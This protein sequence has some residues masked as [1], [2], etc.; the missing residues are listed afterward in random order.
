MS[1]VISSRL[2]TWSCPLRTLVAETNNCRSLQARTALKSTKRSIKSFSGLILSGLKSYGDRYRVSAC[3]QRPTGVP[4]IGQNENRR[5]T[6]RRCTSGRFPP[7]LAARQNSVSRLRA[8]S[9]PPRASPS[10][11]MIAL[12]AP[13]DAPDMPSTVRRPSSSRWSITPQVKAPNAP[14]PCSA[15]LMRSPAF[16]E[17][18]LAPPKARVR[19][20]IISGKSLR[21]PAAVDRVG[22]A[23]YR[24]GR[25]AAEEHGKRADIF[26]LGELVHR[27]FLGHQLDGLLFRARAC[28]LGARVD[29]LLHERRQHPAGANR[30]TGYAIVCG[31]H[32]NNLGQSDK[33]MFGGDISN[34]L[35]TGH[36]TVGRGDIDDAAPFSLFHARYCNADR[37]EGRGQ[38]GRNDRVPFFD[39]E[40]LDIRNELDSGIVDQNVERDEILFSRADNVG[41]LDRFGRFCWSLT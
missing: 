27:L 23:G 2:N 40:V 25:V 17:S 32:G 28:F 39:R 5:S 19:N 29:L 30:V 6:A 15:T 24:L 8:S 18:D 1:A 22:R 16:G 13:A 3:I 37:M 12:T 4:S 35:R 36:Q 34:F 11:S 7:R 31:L 20:S 14:P 9:G 41:D 38:V 26:R 33:A 21:Y 10:A